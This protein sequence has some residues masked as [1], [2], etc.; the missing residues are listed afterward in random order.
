MTQLIKMSE[1]KVF[2]EV[3]KIVSWKYHIPPEE[4]YLK[5]RLGHIVQARFMV[6]YILRYKMHWSTTTIG[7][8][9]KFDH[10]TVHHGLK[11]AEELGLD[12]EAK[13][14]WKIIQQKPLST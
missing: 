12:K 8:A 9:F 11:K 2:K 1:Q 14:V 6:W 13:K 3:L 10:K 5:I 7:E 4:L